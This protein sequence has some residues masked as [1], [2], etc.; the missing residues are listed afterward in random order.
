MC[1]D[2][3]ANFLIGSNI[4]L[5]LVLLLQSYNMFHTVDFPTG[6]SNVSSTATDIIFIDYSRIN[7]FKILSVINDLSD[8]DAPF[9]VINNILGPQKHVRTE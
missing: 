9:L 5:Q 4:T 2:L 3:N 8:H 6:T 1:G 7:S